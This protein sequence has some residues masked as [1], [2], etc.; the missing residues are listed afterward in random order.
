MRS[1]RIV[2]ALLTGLLCVA[3][4][5][6]R[7]QEDPYLDI[8]MTMVRDQIEKEGVSDPRVLEAMREVPRHLFVP[9]GYR[10]MAYEP[11]PLPIGEGQT[12]SQ[13]FV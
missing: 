5:P 11:R 3:S 13:P 9:S 6:G 12:I 8:R 1:R 7:T 2:I 4:S 10:R